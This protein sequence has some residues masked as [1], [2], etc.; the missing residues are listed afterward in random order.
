[1]G[2]AVADYDEGHSRE[3]GIFG[4]ADGQA[5]DVKAARGEHAGDM[6]Q[7]AGDVLHGGREDVAHGEVQDT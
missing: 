6:G 1:M 4:F 3:A 7:Y 5:I 2:R